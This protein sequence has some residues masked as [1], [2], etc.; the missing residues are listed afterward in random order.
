ML[1]W[2]EVYRDPCIPVAINTSCNPTC[3]P[4]DRFPQR[5]RLDRLFSIDERS[6]CR[7]AP[8]PL[9]HRRSPTE[10]RTAKAAVW[11]RVDSTGHAV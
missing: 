6:G 2:G 4:V 1:R 3:Q 10:L 11:R 9:C 5:G 7:V 8:M